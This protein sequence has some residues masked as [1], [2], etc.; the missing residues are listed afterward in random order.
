MTTL[1][2]QPFGNT[3]NFIV[4]TLL[5]YVEPVQP[6]TEFA[7]ISVLFSENKSLISV[8]VV[9]GGRPVGLISRYEY[10]DNFTQPCRRE[11]TGKK[12]C[13]DMMNAAPLLVEKSTPIH[14]LSGFLSES[15]I[16]HLPA[17]SSSPSK[18]ATWG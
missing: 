16:L 6:E 1:V 17:A 18:A 10:V 2:E 4:E 15:E 14:E 12:S 7:K 9:Q 11:L 8:P 3:R 5:R 13:A